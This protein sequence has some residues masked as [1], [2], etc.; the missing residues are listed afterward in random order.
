ME[1]PALFQAVSRNDR[2]RFNIDPGSAGTESGQP[3]SRA[4]NR[5][6]RRTERN[7]DQEPEGNV[8]CP[9]TGHVPQG[10]APVKYHPAYRPEPHN[11]KGTSWQPADI[12]SIGHDPEKEHSWRPGYDR[13]YE[14]S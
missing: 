13:R 9:G 10:K 4:A 1:W 6:L 8:H 5:F 3:D 2:V 14:G 11:S 7:R 12:D